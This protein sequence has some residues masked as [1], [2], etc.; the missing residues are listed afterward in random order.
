MR[1]FFLLKSLHKLWNWRV[2]ARKTQLTIIFNRFCNFR[3]KP[4]HD[5]FTSSRTKDYCYCSKDSD[6]V[7]TSRSCP[8]AGIFNISACSFGL[9]TLTSFP[10]FYLA[11]KSVRREV[12]GLNP[13]AELH[14]TYVDLHP[15][16]VQSD[17]LPFCEMKFLW[18]N[19]YRAQ[20]FA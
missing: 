13:R 12:E 5:I 19:C 1:D 8:P 18:S 11:D 4:P 15:V 20:G 16:S 7:Y 17:I 2:I 14:E 3:Y 10:H 9:P 6:S